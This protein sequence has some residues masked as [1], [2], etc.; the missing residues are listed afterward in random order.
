MRRSLQLA[1]ILAVAVGAGI[2]GY[3]TNRS[4][5]GEAVS[6]AAARDASAR[7]FALSLPDVE[8]RSQALGQWRGKVVVVNFWATWC[9]PCRKEVPDFAATSRQLSDLP[10]QFVGLSIDHADNVRSF[11]AEHRVPYPL[12]IASPQTLELAAGLGNSLQS[13]PFTAIFDRE[14]HLSYAKLGTL[15][16]AELEGKIRALLDR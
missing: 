5:H 10:V 1:L 2:A 7:L 16:A 9:A 6:E 14:G 15:K 3:W 4:L 8:G 12:L 11:Q 13:L